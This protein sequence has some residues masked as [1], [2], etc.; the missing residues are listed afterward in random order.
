MAAPDADKRNR[1]G[2]PQGTLISC[3]CGR[4]LA[5]S[6]RQWLIWAESL[7]GDEADVM[8]WQHTDKDRMPDVLALKAEY[9]P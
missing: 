2:A 4:R 9:P 8:E 6:D 7:G 1:Q 5:S 3:A